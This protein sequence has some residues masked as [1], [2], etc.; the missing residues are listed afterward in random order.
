GAAA[1][2]LH[3]ATIYDNGAG[4]SKEYMPHVFGAAGFTRVARQGVGVAVPPDVAG[5]WGMTAHRGLG[6][7]LHSSRSVMK[8]QAPV[9]CVTGP[10]VQP[11]PSG[12]CY[13]SGVQGVDR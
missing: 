6:F 12:G 1:D 10:Y 3:H 9:A 2:G 13:G 5:G 8:A 7:E 4:V 11:P